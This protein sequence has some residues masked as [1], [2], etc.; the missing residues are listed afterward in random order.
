MAGQYGRLGRSMGIPGH[1]RD[2]QDPSTLL[3]P[4]GL[5]GLDPPD[6]GER[7]IGDQ[8]VDVIVMVVG[9]IDVAQRRDPRGLGVMVLTLG[10]VG[11]EF[12]V[13]LVHGGSEV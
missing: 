7:D 13:L 4:Y 3:G 9:D 5:D 1:S 2:K 12:V 10:V 11:L 6:T 8:L